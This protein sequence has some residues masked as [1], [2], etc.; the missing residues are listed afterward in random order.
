MTDKHIKEWD[1]MI[2][3]FDSIYIYG[4]KRTAERLYRYLLNKVKNAD[5]LKGFL[6][7]DSK[8]NPQNLCGLPVIDV[9]S[10]KN[11]ETCILIP[12]MGLYKEQISELLN[13]MGFKNVMSVSWL[14]AEIDQNERNKAIDNEKKNIQQ[15][16]DQGNK[17]DVI[18]RKK[19]LNMLQEGQPDFGSIK[20]YQSLELIGLDGV[21]PTEYRI[22]TYEL[23]KTLSKEDDV[24]DIGCNTGF[25]DMSIADRVRTITGIEYDASLVKIAELVKSYLKIENCVF[26]NSDFNAWFKNNA[27]TVTYS[28]IFSFAIHHWL[29][30]SSQKYVEMI[31][32]LLNKNGHLYFESHD[33][34]T[35][36]MFRE[37]YKEFQKLGY[38]II[39]END[40]QDDGLNRRKYVLLKKI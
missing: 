34:E 23:Y 15:N 4:A 35:D 40:I 39:V 9:N 26:Y 22:K 11:Y 25:L 38:R 6:V 31:D 3:H 24:L 27:N 7:T 32:T 5:S 16:G 13:S 33:V 36:I 12:H 30:I 21:R 14:I 20:P 1:L 37:C 18:I 10:F 29:N 19:I 28:A 8:D 17:K 2:N